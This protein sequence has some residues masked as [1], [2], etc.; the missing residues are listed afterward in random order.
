MLGLAAAS[1]APSVSSSRADELQPG[2]DFFGSHQSGIT[3]PQQP[4]ATVVAFDSLVEGRAGLEHLLRTLTDRIAALMRGGPTPTSADN[5]PPPD[6]G[7]MGQSLPRD[8]LTMTVALG[9]SLFDHRYG[10]AA[11]K[12]A[13]LIPME[14]FPNDA[15]EASLCHGDILIQFCANGQD[16]VL[17]A[18]R[19]IIRNTPDLLA[20]RWKWDGSLRPKGERAPG[21]ETARN[22]LGFKDGTANPKADD[23][24]LMQQLIWTQG[25]KAGEPAWTDGGSY[26]VV[27]I[28]RNFVERWDR[29]ALNEQERI[30]GRHKMSGAPIGKAHEHDEPDFAADPASAKTDKEAHIRLA[31][32]RDHAALA[33]RILRRGYNYSRGL[34]KSGQMDMGLLFICYQADLDSG[35]RAIQKR[36]NGEALEEYIKPVGGGYFF[37]LPGVAEPGNYLGQALIEAV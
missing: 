32:P 5:M 24:G 7:I 33:T 20:P 16:T 8:G 37:A 28:I 36:L 17:H 1:L 14:R 31:N 3:T 21:E 19:D 30:I 6:S 12:P 22:A 10:L 23:H 34:S 29:T 26:Q 4:H 15:L 18:L 2:H 25:D 27:R 13:R 11:Q 9:A 35:F